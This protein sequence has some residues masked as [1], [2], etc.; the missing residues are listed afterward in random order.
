MFRPLGTGEI[1]FDAIFTSLAAVG[2]RGW[3][4][5]EQDKRLLPSSPAPQADVLTSVHFLRSVLAG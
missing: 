3:L 2:Y 5:I 1:D 4:V